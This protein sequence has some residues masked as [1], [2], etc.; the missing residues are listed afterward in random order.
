MSQKAFTAPSQAKANRQA[1]DW[2]KQQRGLRLIQRTQVATGFGP[3]TTE[4][5]QWTVTIHF[6]P[7][8]SN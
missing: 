6:E 4:M 2:W 8:N 7:E 5:D 1:D 3:S